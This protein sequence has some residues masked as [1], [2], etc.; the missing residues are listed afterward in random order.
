MVIAVCST[1][2]LIVCIISIWV[3]FIEL[4]DRF[5]IHKILFALMIF[6]SVITSAIVTATSYNCIRIL[7]S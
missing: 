3:W 5:K 6:M 7:S 4:Y 2:F 1:I